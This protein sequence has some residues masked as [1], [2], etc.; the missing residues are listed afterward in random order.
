MLTKTTTN[1]NTPQSTKRRR[2]ASQLCDDWDALIEKQQHSAV[3]RRFAAAMMIDK[4]D[5]S[6]RGA[7]CARFSGQHRHW[8]SAELAPYIKHF[9]LNTSS[10]SSSATAAAATRARCAYPTMD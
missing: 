4:P 2:A 1:N 6:K 7:L 9:R 8:F 10:F 5:T 3:K